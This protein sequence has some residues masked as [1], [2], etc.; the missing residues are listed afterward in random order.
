M[1]KPY[2]NKK[3]FE[4]TALYYDVVYGNRDVVRDTKILAQHVRLYLP[5]TKQ[6]N[7]LDM[8]CGTGEHAV[9]FCRHG[10]RVTG[11]DRSASMGFQRRR[12][13]S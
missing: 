1:N 10:F 9:A 5:N 13:T 7:M 6:P 3:A 2:T 11:I 8:G 12:D 4:K